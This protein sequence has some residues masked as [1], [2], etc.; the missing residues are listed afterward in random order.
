MRRVTLHNK[1]FLLAGFRSS[2]LATS[3]FNKV[4]LPQQNIQVQ[5]MLQNNCINQGEL[6]VCTK[7]L[8]Q[9]FYELANALVVLSPTAEDEEIE[10]RI[11]VG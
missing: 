1:I 6:E 8:L 5:L 11:S 9:H 10:V 2:P 7:G 4:V 3:K